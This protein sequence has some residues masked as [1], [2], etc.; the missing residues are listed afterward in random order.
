[1]ALQYS[2]AV[3]NAQLDAWEATIGTA[4][5]MRF[6]DGVNPVDCASVPTANEIANG[7]LP[8]DWSNAASAGA[9]TILGGPFTVTG[10]PAAST[11][12]AILAYRLY[13]SA[14]TVCHEQ[15]TV[16]VTGSGGDMTMDNVSIAD[17]Q[18]MNV[19]VLTRTSGNA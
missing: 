8:L 2:V 18:T 14:G 11:G 16:T 17:T 5:I 7:S 10:L 15:G 9:K 6:Y 4:P 12:T 13:N 3:R 1:M 19:N